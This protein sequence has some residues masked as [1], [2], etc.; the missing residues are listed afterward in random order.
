MQDLDKIMKEAEGI[1]SGLKEPKDLQFLR[2]E[3]I[4]NEL[5]EYIQSSEQ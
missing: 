3:R 5:K 4:F 1:F 2:L